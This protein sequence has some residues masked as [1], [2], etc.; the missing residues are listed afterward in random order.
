MCSSSGSWRDTSTKPAFRHPRSACSFQRTVDR[1]APASSRCAQLASGRRG[2]HDSSAARRP[3][4]WRYRS[5]AGARCRATSAAM[6][7]ASPRVNVRRLRYEL[8]CSSL[9]SAPTRRRRQLAAKGARPHRAQFVSRARR[10]SRRQTTRIV[11][12]FVVCI[13]N[14]REVLRTTDAATKDA[15][16]R[17][18]P[19]GSRRAR[20]SSA[21]SP[22]ATAQFASL[23]EQNVLRKPPRSTPS[24]VSAAR[25][26]RSSR[27]HPRRKQAVPAECQPRQLS[28]FRV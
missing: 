3:N 20:Q 6:R 8:A 23:S 11:R 7:R 24:S 26:E 13:T 18:I 28:Y 16:R 21:P 17:C 27:A 1:D 2:E 12:A 19:G 15:E 25:Q 4:T 9:A 22:T 5:D 14:L 10:V